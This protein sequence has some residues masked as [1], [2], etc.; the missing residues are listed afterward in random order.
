MKRQKMHHWSSEVRLQ[1]ESFHEHFRSWEHVAEATQH[2]VESNGLAFLGSPGATF[3]TPLKAGGLRSL[4]QSS[5]ICKFLVLSESP[6]VQLILNWTAPTETEAFARLGEGR[7]ISHRLDLLF[8][9]ESEHQIVCAQSLLRAAASKVFPFWGELN[10]KRL[11]KQLS[12]CG[13]LEHGVIV[14][15]LGCENYFGADYTTFFGGLKKLNEAGFAAV[16]PIAEGA[17]VRL[18]ECNDHEGFRA[19]QER[20]QNALCPGGFGRKG[21]PVPKFREFEKHVMRY[22]TEMESVTIEMNNSQG[23]SVLKKTR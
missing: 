2:L 9:F 22:A 14:P 18:P 17:L 6:G 15:P 19:A 11:T 5:R 20:V 23:Q 1:V 21:A 10:V 3:I 12:F 4:K 16:D 13:Q 7:N 8:T